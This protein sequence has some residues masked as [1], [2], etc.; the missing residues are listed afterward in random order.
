[1]AFLP[2]PKTASLLSL[3]L[4]LCAS[5]S[6]PPRPVTKEEALAFAK[7]IE[8]AA[9]KRRLSTLNN[10]LDVSALQGRTRSAGGIFENSAV[11]N[12]AAESFAKER[13]GST[14][15]N[16]LGSDGTYQLIHQY[17]KDH[18]QHLLFRAY[19]SGKINYHDF[20][21]IKTNEGVK[22]A[23]VFFFLSGQLV[24][25]TLADVLRSLQSAGRT[26]SGNEEVYQ[27]DSI[28]HLL[29]RE[30]SQKA[31]EYY[32]TLPVV[33]RKNKSFQLIHI[34]I[35]GK[36][37]NEQYVEA[38]KEYKSLF[39]NDPSVALLMIKAYVLQKDYSHAL[40]SINTLD[41]LVGTD[42]YQDYERGII[43]L[44]MKDTA[45]ATTCLERNHRN[46]P[47]FSQ[48]ILRLSTIYLARDR[49]KAVRL[50]KNAV[51]SHYLD[52]HNMAELYAIH[53]ELK[54]DI[55]TGQ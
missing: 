36:L 28:N 9:E 18:I 51:D 1:M 49:N 52:Q 13:F 26:G 3:A 38:L 30:E 32:E 17:E 29:A 47:D 33:L 20:E 54:K 11:A 53:P 15:I 27:A 19:A 23:D 12:S 34:K 21:L 10:I 40:A 35:A 6:L 25:K 55:G 4:V 48:S 44:V 41:S 7:K 31:N 22:A 37:G 46:M 16:T 45:A 14:L 43:Y 39:P 24:S 2:F 8:R 50:L 42:P 5:C